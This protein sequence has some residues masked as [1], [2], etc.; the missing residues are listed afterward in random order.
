MEFSDIYI[1]IRQGLNDQ[2]YTLLEEG[3]KEMLRMPPLEQILSQD[4]IEIL[5]CLVEIIKTLF[6]ASAERMGAFAERMDEFFE[7]ASGEESQESEPEEENPKVEENF[8]IYL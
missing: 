1:K 8:Y 3:M 4:L 7:E 2:D 5:N 6:P